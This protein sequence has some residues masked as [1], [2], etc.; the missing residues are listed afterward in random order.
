MKL[1]VIKAP[2]FFM[3]LF[4][5]ITILTVSGC[6]CSVGLGWCQRGKSTCPIQVHLD[7]ER[8]RG[9][10]AGLLIDLCCCVFFL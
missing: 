3:I 1:A 7:L 5:I 4:I 8:L 6:C 10:V 2:H 9:E